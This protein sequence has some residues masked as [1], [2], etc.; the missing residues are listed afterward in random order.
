MLA[1]GLQQRV[2]TS[3]VVVL[4]LLAIFF[5]APRWAG[6]VVL[7]GMV[8]AG[9][10]EW[11]GFLPNCNRNLRI[12]Y[13][14]MVGLF[15]AGVWWMATPWLTEILWLALGWWVVAFFWVLRFPTPIPRSLIIVGGVF[16]MVP[17]WLAL[18]LLHLN[19][20]PAWLVFFFA[21]IAAADTGAYFTGRT[22]GR[23]RLAPRVSPGK[24]WEGAVGGWLAVTAVAGVGA[25]LLGSAAAVLIPLCVAV[26]MLSVVGDLTMSMFKRHAG[27]KDS[28]RLFPGHGGVLDRIDSIAAGAPLFIIGL[29]WL[30]GPG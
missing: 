8:L 11:A 4:L 10:W 30:H 16:V 22:V 28:G 15:L 6:V 5:L 13:T 23:T 24:T 9:A 21:V 18:A 1:E 2:I 20:G 7:A 25:S 26:A 17:G 12:V 19:S 3:L 29:G 14:V 27:L